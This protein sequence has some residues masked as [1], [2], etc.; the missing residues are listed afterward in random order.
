MLDRLD[1]G[2]R[3]ALV[4]LPNGR[5]KVN[6]PSGFEEIKRAL[7]RVVARDHDGPGGIMKPAIG[8][9]FPAPLD[10]IAGL[11]SLD[12]LKTIVFVS[13][14]GSRSAAD[15]RQARSR[16]IKRVSW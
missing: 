11:R 2:D 15:G 16:K 7:P 12:G 1:L 13:G 9:A 14:A 8:C 6:L 3:V 5:I 4:T 10:F